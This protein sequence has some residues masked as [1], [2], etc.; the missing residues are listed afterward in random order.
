MSN[1]VVSKARL[2]FNTACTLFIAL[3]F[4]YAALPGLVG[5]VSGSLRF[6]SDPDGGDKVLAIYLFSAI[7]GVIA[8]VYFIRM[9]MTWRRLPRG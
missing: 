2:A 6:G 4:L 1:Q 7:L 9:V 5:L 8:T 3:F